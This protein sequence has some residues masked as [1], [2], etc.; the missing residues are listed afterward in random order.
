MHLDKDAWSQALLL[1]EDAY[2][3]SL[4][5]P[6]SHQDWQEDAL[7][8]MRREA[9]DPRG[10]DCI[11]PDE[12]ERATEGPFFPFAPV[13]PEELDRYLSVVHPDA[14]ARLLV[15]MSCDE[16]FRADR[17]PGFPGN[18]EHL[19][20]RARTLL[21]RFL[22]GGTLLTN[23]TYARSDPAHDYL[24]QA[25]GSHPYVTLGHDLGLIAVTE[26]EVGLFWSVDA[27]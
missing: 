9:S 18:R 27:R 13:A 12:Y 23:S 3:I 8:V 24:R 16:S 1:F 22:P 5:G 11:L 20:D 10:F 2:V 25:S 21:S 4:V 26:D 7:P 6:R 14:A 19:L 15:A 17:I